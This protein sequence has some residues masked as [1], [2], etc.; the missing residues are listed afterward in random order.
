MSAFHLYGKTGGKFPPNGT[1]R[2]GKK[3]VTLSNQMER[4][5]PL[6]IVG[7]D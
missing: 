3:V 7:N 5:L 2:M 1:V 4:F 6:E